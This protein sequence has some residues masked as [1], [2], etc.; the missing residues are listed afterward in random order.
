ME[1]RPGEGGEDAEQFASELGDVITTICRR[2]AVSVSQRTTG[3]T[4]ILT[5][6]SAVSQVSELV[7]THRVQRIPSN[8]SRRHTS[9]ATVVMLDQQPE[10]DVVIDPSEL[11][12]KTRRGSGPG[13]QHRNTTDSA[14]EV[15][16]IPTGI[17][18]QID[19]GR[20]QHQNK[21]RALSI[22]AERLA[23]MEREDAQR[24]RNDGRREQVASAE[25][26]A[27]DFTW[28][29]QRGEVLCHSTGKRYDLARFKQ[30]KL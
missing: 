8:S 25:R 22:L 5:L 20:S 9:T 3:R 24:K 10:P 2:K 6:D 1:I 23:D 21:E 27:K 12:I 30:G 17:M 19:S 16:H 15:L 4:I 29:T 7:G 26:P 28:N 14:V 13:G 18:V 11:R